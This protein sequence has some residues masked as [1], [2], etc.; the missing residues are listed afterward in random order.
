MNL[1]R[2]LSGYLKAFVLLSLMIHPG[3]AFPDEKPM[4]LLEQR[5]KTG[6]GLP[7]LM[8]YAYEASPMIKAGRAAWQATL[9]RYRVDT[10]Y[11]DPMLLVTY[12]PQS[13]AD[14]LDVKK[15]EG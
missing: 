8:A 3:P 11:P 6:P 12:W 15:Y 10:A 5:L 4:D 2:S 14:D 9:E 7:D 13:M 1:N